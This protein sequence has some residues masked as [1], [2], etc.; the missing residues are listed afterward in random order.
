M[1]KKIY[2]AGANRKEPITEKPAGIVPR[3]DHTT[4]AALAP[5]RY[6]L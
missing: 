6:R 2:L 4:R 5:P 3:I 1:R